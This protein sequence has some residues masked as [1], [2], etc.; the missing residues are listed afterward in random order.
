MTA[1]SVSSPYPIFTDVDGNPLEDG[2][3]YLGTTNLDPQSNPVAVFWD[4]GLTIPAVQPIRTS[5]GYPVFNGAPSRIYV[6][7]N[8]SI[9]VRN[10][11]GSF[12]YAAPSATDR[13]NSSVVV[14]VGVGASNVTYQPSGSGAIT[15]MTVEAKLR[16]SVSVKD[17]GAV[18]DGV[19]DDTANLQAANDAAA[20]AGKELF[21]PA[22]TYMI[23]PVTATT[24]WCGEPGTVFKYRGSSNVI[25]ITAGP[26]LKNL[27][28][29]N[30]RI[31]GNVSADPEYWNS[32]NYDSFTGAR[33]LF[34]SYCENALVENCH[35]ENT[36]QAGFLFYGCTNST[37]RSCTAKR[38]R[39]N[40]GDCFIAYH[41]IGITIDD[42]HAYDFTRIGFVVD[43]DGA[44]LTS[45]NIRMKNCSAKYGHDASIHYGGGEY[46]VGCW[47]ENTAHVQVENFTAIDQGYA[48][49]LLCSGVKN[50]GVVGSNA[51]YSVNNCRFEN[52]SIG[53]LS[54]SLGTFPVS[55]MASNIQAFNVYVG[56][57]FNA[58]LSADNFVCS[59]SHVDV[60][61]SINSGQTRAYS[62]GVE[63][64][65]ATKPNVSFVDCTVAHTNEN[66]TALNGYYT[67]TSAADIGSFSNDADRNGVQLYVRN[68]HNIVG[69]TPIWIGVPYLQ[70]TSMQV[71]D[72]YV[73]I[74]YASH[75]GN[76]S[77][78]LENC[79]VAS[80]NIGESGSSMV[81]LKGC[82]VQGQCTIGGDYVW[83]ENNHFIFTDSA[84]I[85]AFSSATGKKPS[86]IASGNY[87]EKDMANGRAIRFGFGATSFTVTIS[88]SV[89]YNS[90]AAA[91]GPF[92]EYANGA[93]INYCCVYKDS[94]VTNMQNVDEGWAPV[95]LP[96]GVTAATYH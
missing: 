10:K 18:G 49:L 68:V 78:T 14:V 73:K 56:V 12:V 96:T 70:A 52:T 85:W 64:G 11:N 5:G 29:R 1:L 82:V 58:A 67:S 95:A 93:A 94:N 89:F 44:Q 63:S 33:G 86:I 77:A 3:I 60:D 38:S 47:M 9:S 55:V 20:A 17:F 25:L 28:F 83:L 84:H 36:R 7:G 74:A 65:L 31:D 13:F 81:Y 40:F 43:T 41:S 76:A 87:F 22:G 26:H 21:I 2:F 48:G 90:G 57:E 50:N 66:L 80:A 53:F 39:G 88:N 15:D 16:E 46:N 91:T 37:W 6:D 32:G 24:S 34:V 62:Y 51:L 4:A 69:T 71:I 30:L 27:S 23:D 45:Y 61:F 8:C 54:Y 92:V 59:N 72:C 35:A 19:T 79:R 42:C 75:L